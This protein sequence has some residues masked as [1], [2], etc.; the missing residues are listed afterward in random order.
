LLQIKRGLFVLVA[1]AAIAMLAWARV[2]FIPLAFAL[3]LTLSLNPLVSRL[4]RIGIPRTVGAALLLVTLV[5]L[6]QSHCA[7]CRGRTRHWCC[8]ADSVAGGQFWH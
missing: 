8:S 3:L 2:F 5:A 7:Q 4:S 1:F 6:A